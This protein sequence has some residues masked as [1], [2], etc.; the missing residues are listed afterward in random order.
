MCKDDIPCFLIGPEDSSWPKDCLMKAPDWFPESILHFKTILDLYLSKEDSQIANNLGL[1][2][3]EEIREFYTKH[4]IWAFKT[5]ASNKPMK[6]KTLQKLRMPSMRVRKEIFLRDGYV[7]QYCSLPVVN[8]RV[9]HEFSKSIG[10][11][12]FSSEKSDTKAN[13]IVLGF[14]ATVDHVD[15]YSSGGDSN[16]ENLV[17]T[18]WGCNFGKLN[19]STE[20]LRISDPRNTLKKV[21]Y[22]WNGLIDYIPKL[23]NFTK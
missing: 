20:D 23:K 7:C 22:A 11:D 8:T 10:T 14:S 6:N 1:L 19:Y 15:P 12:Q 3:S 9:F 13:G 4:A 2:R 21:D 17:T 5:R 18:C 16:M